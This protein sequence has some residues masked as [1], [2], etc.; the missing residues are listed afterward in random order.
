MTSTRE[1]NT[2]GARSVGRSINSQSRAVEGKAYQQHVFSPAGG[3]KGKIHLYGWHRSD[4]FFPLQR[5]CDLSYISELR[6]ITAARPHD[7]D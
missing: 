4:R 5:Q 1:S 7:M 3:V 6:K 2:E